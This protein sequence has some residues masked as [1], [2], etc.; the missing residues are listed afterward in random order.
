MKENPTVFR[1]PETEVIAHVPAG[2]VLDPVVAQLF[3]EAKKKLGRVLTEGESRALL[4]ERAKL[5]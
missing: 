2:T 4:V 3:H 1:R 5:N